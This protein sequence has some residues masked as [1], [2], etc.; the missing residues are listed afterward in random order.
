MQR[1]GEKCEKSVPGLGRV[2]RLYNYLVAYLP[3]S[4]GY[5]MAFFG[6]PS[7]LVNMS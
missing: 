2:H 6:S 5:Y 4:C 7:M 1:T 3:T